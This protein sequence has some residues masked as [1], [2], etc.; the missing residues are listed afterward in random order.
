MSATTR[1]MSTPYLTTV[2]PVR[3]GLIASLWPMG[4]SLAALKAISRSWSMIQP[5][6]SAPA[7]TPSTTTTPTLSPSSCTTK[8]IIGFLRA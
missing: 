4:M 2:S 6:S 3:I 5:A 7:F 8:S 1:P